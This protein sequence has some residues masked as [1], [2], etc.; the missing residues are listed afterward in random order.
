LIVLKIS[1]ILCSLVIVYVLIK[2]SRFSLY[3][4]KA[5]AA[6]TGKARIR[7]LTLSFD[8]SVS[9]LTPKNSDYEDPIVRLNAQIAKLQNRDI[10][11]QK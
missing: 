8:L 7:L 1:D 6:Q 3:E 4:H 11:A 5:S 10:A 2:Q 9:T